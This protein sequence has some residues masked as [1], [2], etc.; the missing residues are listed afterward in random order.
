LAA[1]WDVAYRNRGPYVAPER[2]CSSVP[3]VG[4]EASSPIAPSCPI[5]CEASDRTS[6]PVGYEVLSTIVPLCPIIREVFV[7]EHQRDLDCTSVAIGTCLSGNS[8][9]CR[10]EVVYGVD[11]DSEVERIQ[12]LFPIVIALD[13]LPRHFVSDGVRCATYP[14][15]ACCGPGRMFNCPVFG[16][17]SLTGGIKSLSLAVSTCGG[18]KTS[19][20][21]SSGAPSPLFAGFIDP[22]HHLYHRFDLVYSRGLGFP[23]RFGADDQRDCGRHVACFFAFLCDR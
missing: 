2:S 6:P 13:I 20:T 16:K 12:G 3:L 21:C 5:A 23:C 17:E 15:A 18:F 10:L 4:C 22:P 9:D 14:D 11:S 19:T 8:F 1:K 7:A